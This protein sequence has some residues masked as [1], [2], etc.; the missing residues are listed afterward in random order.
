MLEKPQIVAIS[1]TD[2]PVVLEKADRES[3]PF[4][5]RN[6]PVFPL[7]AVTGQGLKELTWEIVT[8]LN[9]EKKR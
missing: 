2:L 3:G 7:S 9:E 1:K 4:R 8:R 5:E 6:I